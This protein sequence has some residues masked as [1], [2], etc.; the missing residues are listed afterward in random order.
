MGAQ[1]GQPGCWAAGARAQQGAHATAGTN[2]VLALWTR[3][4][5]SPLQAGQLHQLQCPHSEALKGEQWEQCEQ[6]LRPLQPGPQ[7]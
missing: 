4:H 5:L 2:M 1:L 3:D 7:L 6:W